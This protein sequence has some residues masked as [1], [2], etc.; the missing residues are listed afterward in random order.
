MENVILWVVP[1]SIAHFLMYIK[2][3]RSFFHPFKLNPNYPPSSQ[4][5]KEIFRS[6]RAIT[7]C[8]VYCVMVNQFH[9]FGY[10]PSGY[11]PSLFDNDGLQVSIFTHF[12]G[13]DSHFSMVRLS[14]LLDPQIATLTLVLQESS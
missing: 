11:V 4:V 6:M 5:M 13:N 7:I 8:T 2:P 10:L 9:S 1:Y 3:Q 14:F 12:F